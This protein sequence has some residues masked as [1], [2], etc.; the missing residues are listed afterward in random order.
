MHMVGALYS[1]CDSPHP[2]PGSSQGILLCITT[3]HFTE[4]ETKKKRKEK[5]KKLRLERSE[6]PGGSLGQLKKA[7]KV[8]V[9]CQRGHPWIVGVSRQKGKGREE[10]P[11]V[12]IQ[13]Q[14]AGALISLITGLPGKYRPQP[15]CGSLCPHRSQ[16]ELTFLTLEQS[17]SQAAPS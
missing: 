11:G 3:F 7:P 16:K 14:S 5:K 1:C 9:V 15:V 17:P 4:K 2:K 8:L 6:V 13:G 10:R 12:D